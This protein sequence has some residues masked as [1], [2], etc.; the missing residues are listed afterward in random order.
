[1]HGLRSPAVAVHFNEDRRANGGAIGSNTP[2]DIW[3][4][5][6][7]TLVWGIGCHGETLGLQHPWPIY[8]FGL[9][10][11]SR[12]RRGLRRPCFALPESQGRGCTRHLQFLA[13]IGSGPTLPVGPLRTGRLPALFAIEGVLPRKAKGAC[14]KGRSFGS[15]TAL[16]ASYS[17][18]VLINWVQTMLGVASGR[19]YH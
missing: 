14:A 6:L 13:L 18:G 5:C 16:T 8:F 15:G 19:A 4:N 7:I 1:M 12:V 17:S 3:A 2:A 10:R 11:S 9:W